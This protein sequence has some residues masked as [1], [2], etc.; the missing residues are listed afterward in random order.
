MPAD[1]VVTHREAM[2]V[3]VFRLAH[4]KGW[5]DTSD[6]LDYVIEVAGTWREALIAP[7]SASWNETT[8][9]AAIGRALGPKALA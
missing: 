1:R 8:L 7:S 4:A 5:Q 3:A 6:A 9:K 2:R